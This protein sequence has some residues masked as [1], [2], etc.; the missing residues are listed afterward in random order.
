MRYAKN[1]SKQRSFDSSN[2]PRNSLSYNYNVAGFPTRIVSTVRY[3]EAGSL[4]SVVGSL[5]NSTYRWNSTFDPDLSGGGHQPLYRDTYATV[6]DH[7]AVVSAKAYITF[8]N[9]TTSPVLVGVVN[10]DDGTASTTLDTICEQSTSQYQLLGPVSSSK[11]TCSFIP[12]WNAKN[13]LGID[14][15]TSEQYKTAIGSNPAE[16]SILAVFAADISGAASTTIYYDIII[17][18]TVLWTEL[19]TPVQS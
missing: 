2:V 9:P 1:R 15:F 5:V 11:S 14:P 8:V 17:E 19:S 10:D 18:M 4:V 7:Y 13:A 16:D 3:H 6:Y 12:T